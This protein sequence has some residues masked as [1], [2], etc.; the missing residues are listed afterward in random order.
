MKKKLFSFV[1]IAVV[2][3]CASSSGARAAPSSLKVNKGGINLVVENRLL[4]PKDA[5]GHI[6]EPF[7]YNGT[8]YLPVRAIAEAFGLTIEWHGS[9]SLIALEK[10]Y[11]QEGE[12]A[13]ASETVNSDSILPG[14]ANPLIT[15]KPSY[16]TVINIVPNKIFIMLNDKELELKDANG[17]DVNIIL[18]EGTSFLPVRAIATALEMDVLWEEATGTVYLGNS[19]S[20]VVLTE[21]E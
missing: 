15:K 11:G 14:T 19:F 2:V 5:D 18:S 20:S 12:Q 1:I 4:I 21:D 16:E 7:V 13:E 9:L 17:A 8:T 3:I 6:V 10:T